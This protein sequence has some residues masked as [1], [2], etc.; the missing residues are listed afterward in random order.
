MRRQPKLF[1]DQTYP[2]QIQIRASG[3]DGIFHSINSLH[4]IAYTWLPT[5]IFFRPWLV[6]TLPCYLSLALIIYIIAICIIPHNTSYFYA[7]VCT[8]L[9]L[10]HSS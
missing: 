6:E 8:I 2:C 9:Q 7:P 4:A 3:R 10:S 5:D 1:R